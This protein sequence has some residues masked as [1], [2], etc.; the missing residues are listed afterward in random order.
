MDLKQR[1][2]DN[3]KMKEYFEILSNGKKIDD[4]W[5]ECRDA[6]GFTSLHYA[7]ILGKDK[8]FI[9]MIK[10]KFRLFSKEQYRVYETQCPYDLCVWA[11]Y[12]GKSYTEDI[13][14]IRHMKQKG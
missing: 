10:S 2:Q 6:L 1:M 12:L 5:K 14:Y 8:L 13:F 9:D 4:T 11:E 7:L 3:I